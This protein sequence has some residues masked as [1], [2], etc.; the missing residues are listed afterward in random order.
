MVDIHLH[1]NSVQEVLDYDREKEL[2]T[3]DDTEAVKGLVDTRIVKIPQ[4]FV[5]PTNELSSE[6]SYS[7]STRLHIPVIALKDIHEGSVQRKQVV[8]EIN[9][10]SETLGLFQI[11]NHGI[12][13]D[14]MDDMIKGIR[15]FHEQPTE[16]KREYYSRDA[17]KNVTYMS[18]FHLYKAKA[19]NWRDSLP[20]AMAPVAPNPEEFP[21]A[22][23]P[24]EVV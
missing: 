16:V 1:Q 15:R 5:I 18:N 23:R 14:V 7:G 13:E 19:V 12:S 8:E 9:R 10:V 21:S 17:T 3:F 6:T 20:F 2:K 24:G 11:V 4:M 22:C